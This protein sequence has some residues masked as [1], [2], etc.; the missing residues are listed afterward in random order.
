VFLYELLHGSNN[1]W[2]LLGGRSGVFAAALP[3]AFRISMYHY[4]FSLA[5]QKNSSIVRVTCFWLW[6]TF[7]LNS[8][9]S[10]RQ[11]RVGEWLPPV[12]IEGD[13]ETYLTT[14]IDVVIVLR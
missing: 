11:S 12:M 5:G 7:V 10:W 14:T 3:R 6:H 8:F 1:T 2:Q 13:A 4:D 9:R